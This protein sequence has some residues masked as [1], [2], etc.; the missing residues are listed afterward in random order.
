MTLEVLGISVLWIFLFGYV[1]VASIDFGAG[2]S[3]L[4]VYLL[5]KIMS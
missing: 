1:M 5:E 2:F 3:M 4:T